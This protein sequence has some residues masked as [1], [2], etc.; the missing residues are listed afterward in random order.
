[1]VSFQTFNMD[2]ENIKLPNLVDII[3]DITERMNSGNTTMS[4]F[5]DLKKAFDTMGLV[6]TNSIGFAG[7]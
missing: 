1:M 2:L 4:I 5:I 6:V 3:T 7:I